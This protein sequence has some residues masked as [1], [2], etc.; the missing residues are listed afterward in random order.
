M[1]VCEICMEQRKKN[2]KADVKSRVLVDR[3]A[4]RKRLH[5][6]GVLWFGNFCDFD[7]VW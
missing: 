4:V 1:A 7:G 2:R 3:I 6:C 5:G